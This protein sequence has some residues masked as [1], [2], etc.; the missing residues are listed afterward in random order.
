MTD[1]DYTCDGSSEDCTGIATTTREEYETRHLCGPCAVV[2][3][4]RAEDGPDDP[5]G[6]DMFRDYRAEER[7]AM[8]AARRLK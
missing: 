2:W 4:K 3:D 5:D 8:D 1:R 6:E 7:D